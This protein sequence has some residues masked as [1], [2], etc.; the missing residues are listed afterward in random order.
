M[1]DTPKSK[2]KKSYDS[3]RKSRRLYRPLV[4]GEATASYATL[5]GDVIREITL[6]NPGVKAILMVRDP[7]DRA[8]SHARK[9]LMTDGRLPREIDPEA[10]LR[11]LGKVSGAGWLSTER[12]LQIGRNTC[13]Q[14][15]F[16]GAFDC[17]AS[18]PDR[19]LSTIHDFLG[20]ATGT[21]YFGRHLHDRI[22]PAPSAEIPPAVAGL[23]HDLMEE[24]SRDYRELVK[25]I[26]APGG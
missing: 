7:V 26:K 1:E 11:L 2:L 22:N 13:S 14:V 6:L 5:R 19:L 8:W 16:R 18:Q 20:V 12:S 21:R 4:R 3:L 9:D 25:E 23:L 10:L 24:E 17:I 15:T